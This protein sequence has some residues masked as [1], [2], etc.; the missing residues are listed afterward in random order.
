MFFMKAQP[1]LTLAT[2]KEIE[3]D[4]FRVNEKGLALTEA[5]AIFDEQNIYLSGRGRVGRLTAEV[6]KPSGKPMIWA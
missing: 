5:D 3:R 2:G 4:T 6:E 1:F